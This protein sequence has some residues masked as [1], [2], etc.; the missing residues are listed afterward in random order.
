[1]EIR[2]YIVLNDAGDPIAGMPFCR[3]VDIMGERLVCLPFSDYCDPLVDDSSQWLAFTDKL[4]ASGCPI[5]IRCLHNSVPLADERF[6]LVKEAKWHRMELQPQIDTLWKALP[7]STQRAIHKAQRDN[8]VVQIARGEEA[9]RAFFET[10]LRV[11][12]HKYHLVA[13]PYRFFENIRRYFL[14]DDRGFVLTATYHEELIGATLFLQWKDTLYYKFNASVPSHLTHRPNDLLI[15]EAI[16]YGK[17]RGYS[18]LDFGLSD[19]DQEG[20][21]R[22]KRKFATEEKAISFLR[23]TAGAEP[24]PQQQQ[25]RQLLSELTDLFTDPSVPDRVTER[26]GDALYRFFT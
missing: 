16:K 1:M 24:T 6:R 4:V 15:W 20:L 11:R 10:H 26:A 17:E 19:W 5:V 8:V 12:K 9:L 3:I 21:V 14:E 13:Q 25:M 23:Y 2:A 7:N 22:Y 18:Y